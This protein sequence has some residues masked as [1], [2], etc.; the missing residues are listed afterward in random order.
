[1]VKAK[2]III[3]SII[4]LV[5]F[6]PLFLALN[7]FEF[8]VCKGNLCHELFSTISNTLFPLA[9]GAIASN[10]EGGL[11]LFYLLPFEGLLIGG[12]IGFLISAKKDILVN[13]QLIWK[14]WQFFVSSIILLFFI[15]LAIISLIKPVEGQNENMGG[16]TVGWLCAIQGCSYSGGFKYC[17]E[18][19]AEY[20]DVPIEELPQEALFDCGEQVTQDKLENNKCVFILNDGTK[21][22]Q[23]PWI[24]YN[25]FYVKD[26]VIY[27]KV[28]NPIP[29]P[30]STIGV[31]DTYDIEIN[32][33]TC[34]KVGDIRYVSYCNC[35]QNSQF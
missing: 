8:S 24:Y 13:K 2:T 17:A 10:P 33:V 29:N 22:L 21:F 14:K 15:S 20:P 3:S 11:I 23:I 32:K 6:F 26:G 7:Y 27:Q 1:V 25:G 12:M 4:C 28:M 18:T 9:R 31:M 16:D 35:D 5:L 19:D 30:S 34:G